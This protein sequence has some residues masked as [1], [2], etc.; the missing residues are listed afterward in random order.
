[1]HI[2][3]VEIVDTFAE[4]FGMWASR[5]IITAINE[6][7]ALTAAENVTGFATSVIGCGCEGGIEKILDPEETPDKRP[8]V[9]VILFIT[10]PKKNA[11]ANME[12]LLINR[13]GQCVLTSPTSACYNGIDPT[14]ETIPV[15]V[16]R[17][18][19]FFGDGFQISKRL[20][21]PK[22]GKEARRFW[23]IPVMEGEFL[24]EDTL[25]IQ[26]AYGGGNFLVVGKDVESVLKA[27][28]RAI[29]E[30]KKVENVIMP[31]PGGI[32]RSGSKVGSRYAALKASTNDA[33][34]PTLKAQSK[35]SL[36]KEGENCV[37][38]IVVNALDLDSMKKA[39]KCGIEAAC[40]VEGVTRIT[41]GNYGGKL[42]KFNIHLH[43]LFK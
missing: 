18:L 3:N 22:K 11:A 14:P 2:N 6:K 30:M 32:V 16:G 21:S 35:N 38:E 39:M 13:I 33:F 29:T 26:R 36:L 9:R 24:C 41:A 19:K 8:G 1:M 27:S 25:Y 40:S 34:C 43:E 4:G 12:H 10:S 23:R 42:G 17:K 20:P 5:F 28:E 15:A 7:W 37:M 31:F